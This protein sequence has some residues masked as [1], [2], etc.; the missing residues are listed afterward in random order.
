MVGKLPYRKD[1][2]K[3]ETLL[4]D[5]NNYRVAVASENKKRKQVETLTN[6]K[7][8]LRIPR[9]LP[10]SQVLVKDQK[11]QFP[12]GSQ[13]I[14]FSVKPTPDRKLRRLTFN[15]PSC[16]SHTSRISNMRACNHGRNTTS[17]RN[18]RIARFSAN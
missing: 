16:R 7:C 3:E 4:L 9:Q 5:V 17:G 8:L 12:R 13:T 6:P 14:R 18:S 15:I 2:K 11:A 10:S 1:P